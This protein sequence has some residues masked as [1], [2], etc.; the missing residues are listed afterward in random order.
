M[1]SGSIATHSYGQDPMGYF[2]ETQQY[3]EFGK[4][5]N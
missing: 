1:H 2:K 4:T 3:F 5:K